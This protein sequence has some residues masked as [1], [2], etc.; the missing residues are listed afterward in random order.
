V[1]LL[2]VDLWQNHTHFISFISVSIRVTIII[3]EMM[4]SILAWVVCYMTVVNG[5]F[6][7]KVTYVSFMS[8][9]FRPFSADKTGSIVLN[10]SEADDT[11]IEPIHLPQVIQYYGQYIDRLYAS[12]NGFV[13]ASPVPT[14]AYAFCGTC[15]TNFS[16]YNKG[17]IAGF[18]QDFN[19]HEDK[20]AV[21][22]VKYY[23][24]ET[25]VVY[26]SLPLFNTN[27]SDT[28]RWTFR[29]SIHSSGAAKISYDNISALSTVEK[30]KRDGFCFISGL[31]TSAQNDN[32][33]V[34]DEQHQ[35]SW[36]VW[37]SKIDGVYPSNQTNV[38][39]GNAFNACPISTTWCG[40]PSRLNTSSTLPLMFNASALSMSCR[41]KDETWGVYIE[42]ALLLSETATVS[43]ES[44]SATNKFIALCSEYDMASDGPVVFGCEVT[45]LAHNLTLMS[46]G[47]FHVAWRFRE[48][49]VSLSS[50]VFT[51]LDDVLPIPVF[52]MQSGD[53]V[54]C[55]LNEAVNTC[56]ACDVCLGH[57]LTLCMELNCA[58]DE[59]GV[60]AISPYPSDIVEPLD[61][62]YTTLSCNTTCEHVY[63]YALDVNNMCC[64]IEDLDCLGI[65]N[66]DNSAGV[67]KDGG[68]L[69]CCTDQQPIDC[70]GVCGGEAVYDTC[71]VCGGNDTG[72]KCATNV[73]IE[74]DSVDPHAFYTYYDGPSAIAVSTLTL[75]NLGDS[76]LTVEFALSDYVQKADPFVWIPLGEYEIAA[77]TSKE[78]NISSSISRLY[79]GAN[80]TSWD[81]KTVSIK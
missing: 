40:T 7:P 39:T 6:T 14:C 33:V 4:R 52:S 10:I 19:P 56:E 21:I 75:S 61:S 32:A 81:I 69:V 54:L 65:C 9:N 3:H 72:V 27:V 55:A 38:V 63:D 5:A 30:N 25:V 74:V 2:F 29:V 11:P 73:T 59:A 60:S 18:I 20:S 50:D 1:L 78:F 77:T 12:P 53:E 49:G 15:Q 66:G 17:I 24:D 47:Y 44:V 43:T 36:N 34:T 71:N 70:N 58:T 37:K 76:A 8:S 22:S 31:M 64:E 79:Q 51:L 45:H 67:S 46:S 41:F 68:G 80:V 16:P 35:V 26:D 48:Q 28:R 57:N 62:L 23:D 13:Q 42:I